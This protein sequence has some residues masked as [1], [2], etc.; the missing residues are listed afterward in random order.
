M[1]IMPIPAPYI[2]SIFM[3]LFV[4]VMNGAVSLEAAMHLQMRCHD[5]FICV[6]R[7]PARVLT[8]QA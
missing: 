6:S 8:S 7:C 5:G 1:P 4:Y 3:G 2:S